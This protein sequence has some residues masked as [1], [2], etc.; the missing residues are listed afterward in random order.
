MT[1]FGTSPTSPCTDCWAP[2]SCHPPLSQVS[3]GII[4][5]FLFTKETDEINL[6]IASELGMY[7]NTDL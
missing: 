5:F 3:Q 6:K 1:V 2:E 4:K 7:E